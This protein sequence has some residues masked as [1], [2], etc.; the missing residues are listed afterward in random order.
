MMQNAGSPYRARRRSRSLSVAV[1]Y[2]R[3]TTKVTIQAVTLILLTRPLFVSPAPTFTFHR[4]VTE[5]HSIVKRSDEILVKPRVRYVLVGESFTLAC[6]VFIGDKNSGSYNNISKD[7]TS[8]NSSHNDDSSAKT[9]SSYGDRINSNE[10]NQI[11]HPQRNISWL[12]PNGHFVFPDICLESSNSSIETKRKTDIISNK[13]DTNVSIAT[14]A[15]QKIF[16]DWTVADAK[17]ADSGSYF[18]RSESNPRLAVY[19]V[20]IVGELQVVSVFN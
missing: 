14:A 8:T 3:L 13:G 15:K 5:G 10:T 9:N 1:I 17:M 4:K 18:C 11:Y 6:R 2:Y 19:D 20:R 7:N 12:L 16:A